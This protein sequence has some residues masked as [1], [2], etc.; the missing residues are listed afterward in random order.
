M[1]SRGKRRVLHGVVF[2]G[3]AASNHTQALMTE[4]YLAG[5][6]PPGPWVH[7]SLGS[8][9]SEE[10]QMRTWSDTRPAATGG[11]PRVDAHL[12]A[13]QRQAQPKS[14]SSG[15]PVGIVPAWAVQ[16]GQSVQ[17]SPKPRR[18]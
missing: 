11:K 17:P 13:D 18:S 2:R 7:W 12:S 15:E 9:S 16:P 4:L 8:I 5:C 10:R 14:R 1:G 6:L 3:P